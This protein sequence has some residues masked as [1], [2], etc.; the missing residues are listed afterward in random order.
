M[1]LSAVIFTSEVTNPN[2]P[3]PSW[4]ELTR[5]RLDWR[6][7]EIVVLS[8]GSIAPKGKYFVQ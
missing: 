8:K 4:L 3:R 5:S 2:V 1:C 7:K 6:P